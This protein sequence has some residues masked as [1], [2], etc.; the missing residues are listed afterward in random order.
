MSGPFTEEVKPVLTRFITDFNQS[1]NMLAEIRYRS[2]NQFSWMYNCRLVVLY[3]SLIN[4]T[5]S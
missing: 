1:E 2:S 3:S 5:N 4:K